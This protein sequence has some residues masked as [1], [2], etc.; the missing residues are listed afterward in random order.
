LHRLPST[1]SICRRG[2][3]PLFF[4]AKWAAV[5]APQLCHDARGAPWPALAVSMVIRLR[6][7]DAACIHAGDQSLQELVFQGSALASVLAPHRGGLRCGIGDLSLVDSSSY[8]APCWPVCSRRR[9]GA[10]GPDLV[11]PDHGDCRRFRDSRTIL[12]RLLGV[13]GALLAADRTADGSGLRGRLSCG[14]IRISNLVKNGQRGRRSITALVFPRHDVRLSGARDPAR[15]RHRM[16]DWSARSTNAQSKS[17]PTFDA[18][19]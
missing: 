15:A 1:S 18:N 8:S 4:A 3:R 10:S 17:S 11:S 5:C 14:T 19:K 13:T 6:Y 7:F 2:V 16:P 9:R 12:F